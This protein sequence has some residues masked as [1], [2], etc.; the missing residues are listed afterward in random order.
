VKTTI[1]TYTGKRFRWSE[2]TWWPGYQ[3][4]AP[5]R[6]TAT[7][8]VELHPTRVTIT[9]LRELNPGVDVVQR[10]RQSERPPSPRSE[11]EHLPG[12]HVEQ[13]IGPATSRPTSGRVGSRS[14]RPR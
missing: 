10:L 8:T 3:L 5:S 12:G 2:L 14:R 6:V 1:D 4:N 7:R 9:L 11:G 13:G